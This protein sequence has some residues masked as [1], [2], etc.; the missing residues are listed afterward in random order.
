M[1]LKVVSWNVHGCVGTDRRF[2]P[3]RTARALCA[4]DP[5]LVLLQEVGDHRGVHP[6]VDQVAVLADAL[7]LPCAIG[8]TLPS[9][10]FGYGNAT[11]TRRPILDSNTFDLSVRGREPRLCLRVV[12]DIG[13]RS[14][15]TMNVHLG[16]GP[17]ERRHQ[18]RL[19][20]PFL[21]REELLLAGDFNDFPPGPVTRTLRDL[22]VDVGAHLAQRRTFP[23]RRP[24]LRLDRVYLSP[25]LRA[26][27]AR[28]DGSPAFR[29]AS[30]HLPLVI[31][32]ETGLM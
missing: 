5:D 13:G 32:L 6:P 31:E 9:G 20:L 21:E 29:V 1:R 7:R 25:G 24:L 3:D 2:D 19:L 27:S 26:L 12:V 17:G 23:S 10:P 4:L 22:L 15:T 18:L 28:V 14:L 16:L 11:L 30:D 8:I